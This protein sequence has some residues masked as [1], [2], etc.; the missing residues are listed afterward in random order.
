MEWNKLDASLCE[1]GDIQII[2]SKLRRQ[3][4]SPLMLVHI[5]NKTKGEL[6]IHN[7]R[8]R[9]GQ[10]S[11]NA[12]R[13][14]YNFISN[15]RYLLCQHRSE[16]TTHF[17]LHC[18][19]LATVRVTLLA[20]VREAIAPRQNILPINTWNASDAFLKPKMPVMPSPKPK[21]SQHSWTYTF[22]FRFFSLQAARTP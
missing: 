18:A 13:F 1:S 9:M 6:S 4:N 15:S 3:L 5:H 17:L 21:F 20:K 10:N 22:E 8:M 19:A 2:K 12:H 16:D 11:L 14:K 7:V